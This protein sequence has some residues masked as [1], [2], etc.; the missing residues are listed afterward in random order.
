MKLNKNTYAKIILI[1]FLCVLLCTAFAVGTTQPFKQYGN[2]GNGGHA[3]RFTDDNST[4]GAEAGSDSWIPFSNKSKAV[5]A[6]S[7]SQT[8]P[9]TELSSATIDP[10]SIRNVTI[11]WAEGS[12]EVYPVKDAALDGKILIRE[13][14]IGGSARLPQ[15]NV[16]DGDGM[17]NIDYNAGISSFLFGCSLS[18][19]HLVVEI[20][21]E[22]FNTLLS[23]EVNGASGQY[24][25]RGVDAES[26]NLHLASG[27]MNI[28]GVTAKSLVVDVASGRLSLS[29][30]F[31]N[32][33]SSLASGQIQM[34]CLEEC[35]QRAS[36]STMSGRCAIFIPHDSD[37]IA[38]VEK[39]SGSFTCGFPAMQRDGTYQCGEGTNA[40]DIS[41]MSGSFTLEPLD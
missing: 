34:E 21:V 23:F 2:Y 10:A 18:S 39:M 6:Q 8:L 29:G 41:I 27:Q 12:V 26:F 22:A 7:S 37:F 19:K 38:Q 24:F 17:L 20:P 14:T 40:M 9:A 33:E 3:N 25:I 35:P 30:V 1:A 16:S 4:E 31:Q 36:F 15:M 13:Y 32:V 11:N 5:D 28:D